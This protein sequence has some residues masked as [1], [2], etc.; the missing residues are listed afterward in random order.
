MRT[1]RAI[2][3]LFPLLGILLLAACSSTFDP[4]VKVRTVSGVVTNVDAT[5]QTIAIGPPRGEKGEALSIAYTSLT[6]M[7]RP[8]G[9]SR[10]EDLQFGERVTVYA[11]EDRSTGALTADRI[12]LMTEGR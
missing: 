7:D 5:H 10:V 2:R 3:P 1:T 8:Y 6:I 11:R 9:P 12:V 4:D